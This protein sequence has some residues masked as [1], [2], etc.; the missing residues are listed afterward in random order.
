MA[1]V[2]IVDD[3]RSIRT[4][5]A[6][7]L[8]EG[9]HNVVTAESA[10]EALRLIQ[11]TPPD[12]IVT[13]IILPRMSGVELLARVHADHPDIQVVMIT[14][15][16]T[17][18]TA[19]E[20]VRQGAF[21]YLSK[22]VSSE[23]VCTAVA[24]A[25]RV[26]ELADGL[27]QLEEENRRYREHLEEEVT[28]RG[29][30]LRESEERHRAVVEN[31]VEGIVVVQSGE[32]RFANPSAVA[33]CG[34]PHDVLVGARAIDLIH[35]DDRGVL[36]ARTAAR[37]AG[38][39][40]SDTTAVRFVRGDGEPRWFE[41]RPVR[42][43]WDGGPATLNFVRDVTDER[44]ERDRREERQRRIERYSAA[45]V[46][47]AM[48]PAI[49]SG[50]LDAALRTIAEKVADTL[51]VE[52][53]E[54]WHS[55]QEGTVRTCAELFERTPR[56]HSSGRTPS[57][58]IHPAYTAALRAER[59]IV[60][61][62][63]RRDPRTSEFTEA[64]FIPYGIGALID[65]AVRLG[66]NV[67][68]VF[69][70]EHVGPSRLW[71][72]EDA[73]FVNT[74]A[75][76]IAVAIESEKRRQAEVALERRE[77]E[78]RGLFEDSPVSLFVEDFSEIKRTFDELRARS[79]SDLEAYI[80]DHPEFV[81]KCLRSVRV[82][83]A[84][85]A[86]VQLHGAGS[87]NALLERIA[88]EYP[89]SALTF[90]RDRLL[91]VWRGERVFEST[92]DDRDLNGHPLHV[93]L[94]WSI[95][96]GQEETLERVLLSK[97]DITA[98]VEGE[99]R[100]RR[101]LDGAIEAIGRVT[102]ARDPYTAGHQRRVTELAVALADRLGLDS[103][104]VDAVR[105]SGLL[106]DIGK[107]SIPAEILAKPSG[108]SALEMSLIK[109]HPESAY[110]VLRTIE[111]P[112]PVADIVLQHHERMDGSGYPRGLRGA[113][114]LVE[115]RILAVADVVEAMSSHRPYRAALGIDAALEEVERGR[116]TLYDAEVV[117]ACLELFRVQ[118]FAFPSL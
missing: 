79:V 49:Y 98:L 76:L 53:V 97:T 58:S 111:F 87:K 48:E 85:E 46:G 33:L 71:S 54:L 50:D 28:R 23:A 107:L 37:L 117:D 70:V 65:V 106:H 62:D 114:I 69:S 18:E 83:D 92:S 101:A 55:D 7:F 45:I 20:A 100:V 1:R 42:L 82:L 21:D 88:V 40:T 3:E 86:A 105:A 77:M 78:Y 103:V 34:F 5:L 116:G 6:E 17:V 104:R 95:P 31:A 113:A 12:V 80:K 99:R 38:E 109:V 26:K 118:A 27:R 72:E 35:P 108:L 9:G 75:G 8:R 115:A 39:D 74:V 13:D 61:S 84:N 73:D 2:L 52:R 56:R 102:E 44:A 30:A 96:P 90:F 112:W 14:G 24:Q 57:L 36:E 11:A 19:S 94:R 32:I 89:P 91:A 63:A 29:K 110:E 22:P 4:T 41:M 66:G 15:E 51:G 10:T 68:G 67:V 47:L 64:H 25:A 43:V 60:A 59:S 93:A 81:E 16:P